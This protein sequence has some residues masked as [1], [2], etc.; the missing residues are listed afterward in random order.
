MPSLLVDMKARGG[1]LGGFVGRGFE[2]A[3]AY[4][5]SVAGPAAFGPAALPSQYLCDEPLA[6]VRAAG[7][8]AS[9]SRLLR[10][11]RQPRMTLARHI[12]RAA[13]TQLSELRPR[14]T[15]CQS[16]FYSDASQAPLELFG[17]GSLVASAARQTPNRHPAP[18]LA[19]RGDGRWQ[20]ED[21]RVRWLTAEGS[22]ATYSE[23]LQVTP[24]PDARRRSRRASARTTWTLLRRWQG[25]GARAGAWPAKR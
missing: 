3:S 13:A 1:A 17:R 19:T 21:G 2:A 25:S 7:C 12:P 14:R 9:T 6:D 23:R 15:S 10:R 8:I 20:R 11:R 22:C 4:S 16:F 18:M 24:E 5:R